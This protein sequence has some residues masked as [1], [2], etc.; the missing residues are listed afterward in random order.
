MPTVIRHSASTEEQ[1]REAERRRA[2]QRS[3]DIDEELQETKRALDKKRKAIKLLL[4]GVCLRK[5]ICW[6]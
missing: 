4:L 5:P 3:R 6:D 2:L 1:S